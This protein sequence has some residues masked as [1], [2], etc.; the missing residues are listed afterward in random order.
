[1]CLECVADGGASGWIDSRL[2]CREQQVSDTHHLR[3][4]TDPR[5]VRSL[6]SLRSMCH[7]ASDWLLGR[8]VVSESGYKA[9]ER[10]R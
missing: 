8:F 10:S 4:G 9:A 2:T 1:L 5:N 7:L 3:I 6:D